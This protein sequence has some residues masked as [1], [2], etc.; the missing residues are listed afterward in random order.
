MNEVASGNLG[1]SANTTEN[2]QED[3]QEPDIELH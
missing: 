3:N 2:T 1:C